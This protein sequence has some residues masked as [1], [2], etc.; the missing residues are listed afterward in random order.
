VALPAFLVTAA[1][2]AFLTFPA[3]SVP[4]TSGRLA[5]AGRTSPTV[6][7]TIPAP[8]TTAPEATPPST[9]ST[10]VAVTAPPPA[11]A[12]TAPVARRAPRIVVLG[13]STALANGAGM[14]DWGA[15]NGQLEVDQ[16]NALSCPVLHGDLEHVRQGFDTPLLPGCAEL[17]DTAVSE[18]RRVDADAFVVFIG[19]AQLCDWRYRGEQ[20]FRSIEDP[21]VAA[22]Y[23]EALNATLTKLA[24]VGIPI[25]WADVPVPN[26]DLD[27]SA[28]IFGGVYPGT[29]APTMNSPTRTA[30]LNQID[31]VGLA[32]HP[33]AARFPYASFIQGPVDPRP[34]GLHLDTPTMARLM[35]NGLRDALMAAY[36]KVV[37]TAASGIGVRAI[38]WAP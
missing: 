1:V 31:S 18:A 16:V 7:T 30:V 29:G 32:A 37:T 4:P 13:D 10:A 24:T 34:D 23:L 25:L 14:S 6:P 28:K 21:A 27:K 38:T 9:A 17:I 8:A 36:R 19:S 12:P 33:Q 3:S 22:W 11:P 2:V 35:D 15:R 20:Q 26:W 5:T